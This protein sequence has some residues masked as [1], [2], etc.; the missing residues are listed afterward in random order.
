MDALFDCIIVT[1]IMVALT[2]YLGITLAS[3]ILL[4]IKKGLKALFD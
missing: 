4:E 3:V 2:I 1:I